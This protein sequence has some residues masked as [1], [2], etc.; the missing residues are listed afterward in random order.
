MSD[1]GGI[2]AE[3]LR[4]FVTRIRNLRAEVK[5]INADIKEVYAEAK[6]TGFDNKIIRRIV[7]YMDAVEKHGAADV[8]AQEALFE[9]YKDAIGSLPDGGGNAP[10]PPDD[11]QGDIEH[12]ARRQEQRAAAPPAP[13]APTPAPDIALP[14][15]EEGAR[16]LGRKW[17]E[18][19][20]PVTSNPFPAGSPGRAA[21]D[22]EW[23]KTK[24][25]NGMDLPAELRRP[26]RRGGNKGRG[27]GDA[28]PGAG[29][30]PG[31]S[32]EPGSEEH[33]EQGETV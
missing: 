24:G 26:G 9:L 17:A 27:K 18:E 10:P 13:P 12:Y 4:S 2:A 16:E 15:T 11:D 22:D 3:R 21:F 32:M 14:M 20:R 25:S 19:G 7:A 1:V 23:C 5:G 8:Q 33:Q 29:P 28:P 30:G 6:G 31:P